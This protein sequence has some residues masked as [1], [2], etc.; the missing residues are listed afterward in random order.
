MRKSKKF[1]MKKQGNV[2]G[3]GPAGFGVWVLPDAASRS[4]SFCAGIYG[5]LALEATFEV[6]LRIS[7][8]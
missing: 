4:V 2:V 8:G 6:F 1:H 3:C 5:I 7:I